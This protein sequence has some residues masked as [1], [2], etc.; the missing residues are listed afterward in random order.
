MS[1]ALMK[2]TNWSRHSGRSSSRLTQ[3]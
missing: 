3:L 1:A 2:R